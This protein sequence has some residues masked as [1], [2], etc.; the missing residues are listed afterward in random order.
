MHHL[1]LNLLDFN[2]NSPLS[3]HSLPLS[4]PGNNKLN[5]RPCR[6]NGLNNRQNGCV[7]NKNYRLNNRL[8]SNSLNNKR[9]GYASNSN[10]S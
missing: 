9:N 1:N 8:S 6:C 10:N 4:T 3:N 5:K 7:N 2:L